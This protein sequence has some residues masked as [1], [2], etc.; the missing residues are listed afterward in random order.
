MDTPTESLIDD[1]AART[2]ID[3]CGDFRYVI[4]TL[5]QSQMASLTLDL[6]A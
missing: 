4:A 1:L 3:D 2:T 5:S 6:G